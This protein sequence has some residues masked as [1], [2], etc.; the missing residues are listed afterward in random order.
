MDRV[1]IWASRISQEQF[2][3]KLEVELG[4]FEEE[5][6]SKDHFILVDGLN[7]WYTL[8]HLQA[9][10]NKTFFVLEV[11]EGKSLFRSLLP[12]CSFCKQMSLRS[13]LC[14]AY[15]SC[16]NCSRERASNQHTARCKYAVNFELK[17]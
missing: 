6:F 12:T 10:F 2:E 3:S 17:C 5:P 14:L 4:H 11:R 13:C 1:R 7:K 15:S 9:N 8:S 16:E